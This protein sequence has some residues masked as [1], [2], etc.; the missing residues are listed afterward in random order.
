MP[1]P[2]T[3]II[4]DN[5]KNILGIYN[6]GNI[7]MIKVLDMII[8]Q[9]TLILKISN[10]QNCEILLKTMSSYRILYMLINTNI[11]HHEC[12][13]S[14][15]EC[16]F[17]DTEVGVLTHL[18][19]YNYSYFNKKSYIRDLYNRILQCNPMLENTVPVSNHKQ[20]NALSSEINLFI[21]N[22]II[23]M[24]S[25][26]LSMID[27]EYVNQNIIKDVIKPVETKPTQVKPKEVKPKVKLTQQEK[28]EEKVDLEELKRKIEALDKKKK[29]EEAN[30]KTLKK[31]VKEKEKEY[32]K[33]RYTHE[34]QRK[35]LKDDQD[36]WEQFTR[37]FAADKKVYFVIKQQINDG[38]IREEE[39][40]PPLFED[41]Y[42][43]FKKL[44]E[45]N[46]LN[47]NEELRAYLE[48][49]PKKGT[50][51]YDFVPEDAV[52]AGI[53]EYQAN[54]NPHEN[55]EP[56]SDDE[57]DEYTTDSDSDESSI[58]IEQEI[59][60]DTEDGLDVVVEDNKLDEE[61]DLVISQKE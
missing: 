13:F 49:I 43:Y 60:Y 3:C 38:E 20:D 29:Y 44:D 32:V 40:M 37:K 26:A 39:D 4:V 23:N 58:E 12:Y 25:N 41:K 15:K 50:K 45:Q 6:N 33:K 8:N 19:E 55:S 30:Y 36:K 31:L 22:D 11:I 34:D 17:C 61:N 56:Y 9:L 18:A 52:L 46:K 14:F 16:N 42:P 48:I 24:D 54:I 35:K 1:Q 28:K 51:E 5:N 53:F 57:E 47:T 2:T 27:T 59:H 10:E 21:P 7:A